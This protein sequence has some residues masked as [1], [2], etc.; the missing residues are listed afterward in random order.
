MYVRMCTDDAITCHS[1]SLWDW[2]CLLSHCAMRCFCSSVFCANLVHRSLLCRCVLPHAHAHT[3][4]YTHTSTQRQAQARTTHVPMH[5]TIR[6][7]FWASQM[8][9]IFITLLLAVIVGLAGFVRVCTCVRVY[10]CV[11]V[12][13]CVCMCVYTYIFVCVRMTWSLHVFVCVRVYVL[14][15]KFVYSLRV[16]L[17]VCV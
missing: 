12:C 15:Y 16:C 13:V 7:W 11:Y 6:I 2:R 4:I 5:Q 3:R 17:C 8:L 14:V 1:R 10:V 9:P